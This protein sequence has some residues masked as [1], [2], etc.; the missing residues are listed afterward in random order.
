M[1]SFGLLSPIFGVFF[2]WLIFDDDL[3]LGFVAAML[4]VGGGI[5]LVNK[6]IAP[7]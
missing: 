2:G 7:T 6:R 5:V 4:T 1:T 3:T